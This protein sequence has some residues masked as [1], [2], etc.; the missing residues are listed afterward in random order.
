MSKH[1]NHDWPGLV[2]SALTSFLQEQGI[3]ARDIADRHRQRQQQ[4]QQEQ[5]QQQPNG[6]QP[7]EQENADQEQAQPAPPAAASPITIP[8]SD[9]EE[10]I[11]VTVAASSSSNSRPRRAAAAATSTATAAPAT[12]KRKRKSRR[13]GDD[14]D[15]CSDDDFVPEPAARRS[16]G[17]DPICIQCRSV[18]YRWR[19]SAFASL[20]ADCVGQRAA[21]DANAPADEPAAG[22]APKGKGKAKARGGAR[23]GRARNV[24]ADFALLRDDQDLKKA[25]STV[26]PLK[27]MCIRAL[28]EHID[29]VE[30]LG[31]VSN[32]TRRKLARI[33]CK[34]RAL[35]ASVLPLFTGWEI[36]N[37][38]LFDCTK[39]DA[40]TLAMIAR[41]CPNLQSLHLAFCGRT[42]DSTVA[43][44]GEA[45]SDSLEELSLNGPYL[46]RDAAWAE[47]F[48]NVGGR[49]TK[50]HLDYPAKLGPVGVTALVDAQRDSHFP[51]RDLALMHSDA[52]DA[53][54]VPLLSQF[55]NLDKI[56]L[57]HSGHAVTDQ[58]ILSLF[59]NLHNLRAFS[60]SH[61]PQISDAALFALRWRHATLDHLHFEAI[62]SFTPGGVLSWLSGT[63]PPVQPRAEGEEDGDDEP[64]APAAAAPAPPGANGFEEP[65]DV[66]GSDEGEEEYPG[67]LPAPA[68]EEVPAL[69][70]ADIASLTQPA[71]PLHLTT[72]VLTRCRG[73]N[74]DMAITPLLRATC[75]TLETLG[76]NWLDRLTPAALLPLVEHTRRQDATGPGSPNLKV[77]DLSWVRCVDDPTLEMLVSQLPLT[78][79][80]IFGCHRLSPVVATR[81][82]T[83]VD[84]EPVAVVGSEFTEV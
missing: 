49:L 62:E 78:E 83:N 36:T 71:P 14:S 54:C 29:D 30:A 4:A 35:D 21:A 1:A 33:L 19:K 24:A 84:G 22:A 37:L 9:D 43:A 82:W 5:A 76:L 41:L 80:K 47:F 75:G 10:E 77:V 50:L 40:N 13:R 44:W 11:E 34:K 20:C 45:W 68:E 67:E 53:A 31:D 52:F 58:H 6:E 63:W 69:S 32:E 2:N 25:M 79:V 51:L 57:L 12:K 42:A 38:T 16:P 72:L 26:P 60:I 8:D 55:V 39:L 74:T 28:S 64:A 46:V 81:T 18:I 70:E 17:A 65:M 56:N 27:D 66:D 23:M 3:S 7:V 48:A 73:L 59:R 15:P 61:A